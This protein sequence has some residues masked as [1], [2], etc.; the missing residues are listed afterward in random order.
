MNP[1]N[2]ARCNGPQAK[3][4]ARFF[5]LA[6]AFLASSMV[7]AYTAASFAKRF[8]RWGAHFIVGLWQM[9]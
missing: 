7:P 6:D 4:R 9:E 2:C 1:N 8:A 5:Q 3:Y